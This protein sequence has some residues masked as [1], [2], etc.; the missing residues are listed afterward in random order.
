MQSLAQVKFNK[1]RFDYDFIILRS[2]I[3]SLQIL[4]YE[5]LCSPEFH[6][7]AYRLLQDKHFAH[8]SI[9]YKEKHHHIQIFELCSCVCS[10]QLL[11][12][13]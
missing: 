4:L 1:K 2:K 8:V 6:T 13:F 11:L 10:M 5:N 3:P 9:P 12:M 7:V